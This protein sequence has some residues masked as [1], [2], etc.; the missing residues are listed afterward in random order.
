MHLF[1]EEFVR[2]GHR[3][4]EPASFALSWVKIFRKDFSEKVARRV[5][6]ITALDGIG[7][8]DNGTEYQ[9]SSM[10]GEIGLNNVGNNI[11]HGAES[12]R[13]PD[14]FY[15]GDSEGEASGSSSPS[16]SPRAHAKTVQYIVIPSVQKE[17]I[18]YPIYA[19]WQLCC[20]PFWW[21][22]EWTPPPSPE[23]RRTRRSK[24]TSRW[25][26]STE[27]RK[28]GE[29]DM[30]EP[31]VLEETSPEPLV[32]ELADDTGLKEND[33]KQEEADADL[34]ELMTDE[35]TIDGPTVDELIEKPF[36]CFKTYDFRLKS[37]ALLN[38]AIELDTPCIVMPGEL[39]MIFGDAGFFTDIGREDP[40]D[41]LRNGG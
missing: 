8:T 22:S 21:G 32:E 10:D 29:A 11:K 31:I 34:T 23:A 41:D 20:M 2:E 35:P 17:Y 33:V 5:D 13:L 15:V 1:Y 4:T 16:R 26:P 37:L 24:R 25:K 3:A 7:R 28:A 27:E 6:G 38:G 19:Y 9:H 36:S 40:S 39:G 14:C 18:P 12:K 30:A